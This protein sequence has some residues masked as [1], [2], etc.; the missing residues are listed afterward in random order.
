MRT[1]HTGGISGE[2]D[3]IQGLPKIK[4]IFD[5]IKPKKEK[6]AILS[7]ENGTI[8][9]I[10]EK[11]IKQLDQQGQENEYLLFQQKL[12]QIKVGDEVSIGTKL[13]SGK[14]DLEEYLM[15]LGRENCQNYIREEIQK[16]YYNQGIDVNEK[17]IEIF[18]KQMLSRVEITDNGSSDYL[19]GDIVEYQ[20]V[21]KINKSLIINKKEPIQFRNTISSLKDLA[22]SPPSFLAGISFQNTLKALINYSL[23]NPVD[24]LQGSKE[25]LIVGQLIP[26]GAGF[27]ERL[28]YRREREETV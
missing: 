1:F 19:V 6:K 13:T 25:N 2:E 14:I 16:I 11:N 8:I 23:Y 10:S 7:K 9:S 5:N 4:Q 22:S 12:L 20:Q 17:H 27:F 18:I 24:H 28:K 21:R 15:I 26:L 3:I